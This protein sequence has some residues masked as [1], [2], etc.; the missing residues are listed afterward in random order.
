MEPLNIKKRNVEAL[1]QT[2]IT[3]ELMF[4][5]W[6]VKDTHGNLYQSGFPDLFCCHTRYGHRWVEVKQPTGYRFTPAQL[7]TFPKMC[8]HGSQVW[9]AT[10]HEGIEELLMKPSNWH[11]YLLNQ[12]G[13]A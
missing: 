5:G 9:V 6:F 1:I 3:K 12:R 4:K 11:M 2:A 7:E 10:T 13:F 8:A